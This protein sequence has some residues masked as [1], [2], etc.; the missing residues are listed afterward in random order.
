MTLWIFFALLTA[1]AA[2][3][4]LVPLRRS[5]VTGLAAGDAAAAEA[6]Y[7]AQLDELDKDLARGVI[8]ETGAKAARIEIARRLIALRRDGGLSAGRQDVPGSYGGSREKIVMVLAILAVPAA[9]LGIYMAA[10][11]PSY[12]DQ[13]LSARLNTPVETLPVNQMVARVEQHLA[14]NPSDGRGWE[15]LA[16]VYLSLGRPEDS[17]RAFGNAIRLNGSRE[18]LES[19]LGEALVV[20]ARGVVTADAKAAF[21]RAVALSPDAVKPRFFLAMAYGQEGR[22]D[23]AVKA[24]MQLLAGADENEP[25]VPVARQELAAVQGQVPPAAMSGPTADDVK[26]ASEMSAEDRQ[27]MIQSMVDG[28][29]ERLDRSGGSVEEWERLLRSQ[30]ILGA[31]EAAQETLGK[32]RQAMGADQ[33]ALAR[34]DELEKEL[35]LA[36]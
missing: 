23:E 35:G 18:E 19:G 8:D 27:S 29:Q 33:S 24:W 6:V 13:P 25:W 10:G 1:A 22:K 34:F 32:A 36:R 15:V 14:Q 21:E 12:P 4:I 26:A 31:K 16:P 28:L 20:A 3:S 2:L 5:A 9:A 30:I 17:A 7:K 11:S